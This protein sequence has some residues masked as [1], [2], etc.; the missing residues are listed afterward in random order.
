MAKA[1]F[2]R[3]NLLFPDTEK[4][5]IRTS[6]LNSM[7]QGEL[8]RLIGDESLHD[9]GF[10]LPNGKKFKLFTFGISTKLMC[11]NG[12]FYFPS[13]KWITVVFSSPVREIM[14]SLYQS[15]VNKPIY[16]NGKQPVAVEINHQWIDISEDML[17]RTL[18][19]IVS[20]YYKGGKTHFYDPYTPEFSDSILN[21]A[22]NKWLA[23]HKGGVPDDL[24]FSISPVKVRKKVVTVDF[25]YKYTVCGWSGVFRV[26]TSDPGFLAFALSSGLGQ[27]NAQGFGCCVPLSEEERDDIRVS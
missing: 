5:A 20:G 21:N 9:K 18:S 1:C 19:P 12:M 3:I 10:I 16:I 7:L 15:I 27:K 14:N 24:T 26:K 23:Y 17:V 11:K 8:Y 13:N 25:G 6:S 2:L 22:K 4:I